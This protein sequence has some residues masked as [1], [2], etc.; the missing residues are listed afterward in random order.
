MIVGTAD[1]EALAVGAA[2]IESW[3]QGGVELGGVE[4]LQLI[5]EMRSTA[6]EAVLPPG[7]HPTVP[8]AL[9][10]QAWNVAES[11]WGAFSFVHTRVSCRSG[12]RARGFTTAGVATTPEAAD[13][14]GGRFG[15]PVRLGEVALRRHYD[16]VDLETDGLRVTALDPTPLASSDVQY[17]GTMNLADTP[18]GL[19]LVQVEAKHSG[20]RVERVQGRICDF[21][22]ARW[23]NRLL[24]PYHVVS[25]SIAVETITMPAVRFV[26]RPDELAFTGTEKVGSP[27]I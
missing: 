20:D 24:A 4:C 1:V 10:I 15:F 25:A 18:N 6:R 5:A 9:S 21:A 27:S 8:P 7:L 26:C 12:M 2:K 14:L 16:G 3:D 11:P 13:G 23:G 19:R 17:T 22:P